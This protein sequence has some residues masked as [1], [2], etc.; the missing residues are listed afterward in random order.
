[1]HSDRPAPSARRARGFTL[2][3]LMVACAVASIVCSLAVPGFMDHVRK[4]RRAEAYALLG[5]ARH[6]QEHWRSTAPRYAA[7]LPA[8]TAAGAG[9][10]YELTVDGADAQGYTLTAS[11]RPGTSQAADG[12]CARLRLRVAAGFVFHGA[13]AHGSA[14]FDESQ[15]ARCWGH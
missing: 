7:E 13:A 1:M 15:S 4:A 2:V 9:G 12:G 6:A 5:A 11:A 3:E 14:D 10:R 8:G